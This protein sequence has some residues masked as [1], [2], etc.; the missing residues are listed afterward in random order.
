[1]KI[2]QFVSAGLLA[3][4]L[5]TF[6][7]P[8]PAQESSPRIQGY[9][10]VAPGLRTHEEAITGINHV[11]AGCEISIR[12]GISAGAEIGYLRPWGETIEDL[13]MF[14]VSASYH[15]PKSHKWDRFIFA[16]VSLGLRD[17]TLAL[18]DGVSK[19]D[20]S[21]TLT[22]LNFGFG[23]DYWF[24]TGKGVRFEIRDHFYVAE[25]DRNYLELRF[26]FVFR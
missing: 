3:F 4:W 25:V 11:G 20:A 26:G 2:A 14:S 6:V 10:F 15:R 22:L 7:L 21:E 16:G 24:K 12:K 13:G 1:M 23:A 8:C 19:E 17:R 18:H 9:F 5:L